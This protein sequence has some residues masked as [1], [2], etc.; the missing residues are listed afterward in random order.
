MNKEKE[1]EA[2][3]SDRARVKNKGQLKLS[4]DTMKLT[5]AIIIHL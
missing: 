5:K 1:N 3:V 4:V 2:L